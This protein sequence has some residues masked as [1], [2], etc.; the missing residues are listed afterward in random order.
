M[1]CKVKALWIIMIIAGTLFLF[2][3]SVFGEDVVVILNNS[4]PES[5]FLSTDP[6]AIDCVMTDFVYAENPSISD[7]NYLPL[8]GAAGLGV[9]ERG[10]PWSSGYNQIDYMKINLT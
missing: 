10:D 9:Y 2:S 6:V 4:V 5:V 1:A 7:P 3:N 8:A